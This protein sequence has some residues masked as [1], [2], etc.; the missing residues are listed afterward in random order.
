M[1]QVL[2]WSSWAPVAAAAVLL[3]ALLVVAGPARADKAPSK[4]PTTQEYARQLEKDL[5]TA[6]DHDPTSRN[7]VR[8]FKSWVGFV[9]LALVVAPLVIGFKLTMWFVRRA[10][11]PTDPAQLAMSD[12]WIRAHL[13]QQKAN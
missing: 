2:P 8:L 10:S 5:K 11:A 9:I 7:I 3:A 6:E 1:C 12:P 4:E 13:A